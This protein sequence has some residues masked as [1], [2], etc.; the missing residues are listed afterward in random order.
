[1]STLNFNP[2]DLGLTPY[3]AA[4]FIEIARTY[5][6]TLEEKLG[7]YGLRSGDTFATRLNE[8]K[9]NNDMPDDEF[10]VLLLAGTLGYFGSEAA[11]AKFATKSEK[12]E[13]GNY[14]SH[15]T[16]G[17]ASHNQMCSTQPSYVGTP[18]LDPNMIGIRFRTVSLTM[19]KDGATRLSDRHELGEA[20]LSADQ[21]VGMIRDSQGG[22]PCCIG[23]ANYLL[24]DI[25]PRMIATVSITDQIQAKMK[26]VTRPVEVAIADLQAFLAREEKISTKADYAELTAKAEIIQKVMNESVP[27][28]KAL[29]AEAAGAVAEAAIKQLLAD[30][31][32]PLARLG[33][34]KDDLLL[35]IF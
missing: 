35:T 16:F 1:M 26:K 8:H 17:A 9:R 7:N 27:H 18:C 33:M 34:D 28:L 30:I 4:A 6:P 19:D 13:E 5:T 22:T 23:R 14:T 10:C 15:P 2:R 3:E 25:P 20:I 29:M 11:F 31:V 21:Y 12:D 24:S 32:E